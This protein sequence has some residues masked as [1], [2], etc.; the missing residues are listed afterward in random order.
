MVQAAVNGLGIAYVPES[1]ASSEL[2]SGQLVTVLIDWCPPIP[3]LALYYPGYRHVPSALRALID[4]IKQHR[5]S[6]KA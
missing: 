2:H 1:V 5:H 6:T 4:A 3:G